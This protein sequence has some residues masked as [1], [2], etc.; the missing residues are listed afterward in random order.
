MVAVGLLEDEFTDKFPGFDKFSESRLRRSSV[1]LPT[2]EAR[3]RHNPTSLPTASDGSRRYK[4]VCRVD[5]LVSISAVI[6][7]ITFVL[8]SVSLYSS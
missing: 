2:L 5:L 7:K 6:L 1:G 8:F 4:V 3:I